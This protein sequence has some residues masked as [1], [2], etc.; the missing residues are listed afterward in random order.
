MDY[1]F[2]DD[3]NI[4]IGGTSL[5]NKAI[6][7]PNLENVLM[8]RCSDLTSDLIDRYR[9]SVWILG[10]ITHLYQFDLN[11]QE[12]KNLLS[13]KNI[14]KIE[15]DYN[16][17][18]Y[19]GTI[20]HFVLGNKEQCRC[21]AIPIIRKIYTKIAE[22]A[23]I[24]FMSEK[25]RD[26]FLQH[27]ELKIDKTRILSSCFMKDDFSLFS[28]LRTEP[29]NNKYAILQG[30]GG[31]H[32]MAKGLNQAVDF[33]RLNNLDFDILPIEPYY[34]HIK[35]LSQ[36]TGMVFL[37]I[38]EDT[39]P[40]CTIEAKLLGLNLVI[41]SNV[42]HASEDWFNSNTEDYLKGRPDFFWKEVNNEFK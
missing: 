26:V 16:Y 31:W 25:Q 3:S 17:C 2:V 20:P 28:R 7:E 41:N 18:P 23:L 27:I 15:F 19:R 36:Y 33:C 4:E 14:V 21:P 1:V 11:S 24:F 39:C 22:D 9:D 40:R 37:P 30:Y 38:I 34:D 32:S 12:I 42:Q 8:L 5:T 29:K 6:M 10:N 35:R 13:L